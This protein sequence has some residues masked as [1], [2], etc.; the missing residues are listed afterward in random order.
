MSDEEVRQQV[1]ILNTTLQLHQEETERKHTV[2]LR[3]CEGKDRK[4]CVFINVFETD[5]RCQS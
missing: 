4:K 5:S 1:V 3:R 2:S